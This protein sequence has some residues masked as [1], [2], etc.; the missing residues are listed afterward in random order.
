M[1]DEKP[2][3]EKRLDD[4]LE[5]GLKAL[6]N[7]QPAGEVNLPA[8]SAGLK[9]LVHLAAGIRD[10]P[11]PEPSV[12]SANALHARLAAEVRRPAPGKAGR[13]NVRWL[14]A[15]GLA[16]AGALFLC[17]FVLLAA[18]GLWWLGPLDART[19][20]LAD[21][22]GLVEAA[23]AGNDRWQA[24][25]NGD[26]LGAGQRIRTATDATAKLVFFDGTRTILGGGAEVMLTRLGGRWGD[27]L[28]AELTQPA[29]G[30]Q[31]EVVPFSSQNSQ[32]RVQTPAGLASVHGTVFQ[33]WVEAQG[34]AFFTVDR[35]AVVVENADQQ[36]NL[37]AGQATVS[38]TDAAPDAPSYRFSLSDR[39]AAVEGEVWTVGQVSFRVTAETVVAGDPQVGDLILAQGRMLTADDWVADHI[40][41]AEE[42]AAEFQFTGVVQAMDAEAWEINGVTVLVNEVT[43]VD[44][45]LALGDTALVIYT[46]LEGGRWLALNIEKLESAEE[47]EVPGT[48]S[49]DC[50]GSDPQPT[51]QKLAQQYGVT[52]EEI[53]GWF[54]Q[55]YGFGEIGLAYG[56]SQESGWAVADIFALRQQN[57]GWGEIKRRVRQTPTATLPVATL[58]VATLPVT[59]TLTAT[60]TPTRTPT[61]ALTATLPTATLPVT[62]TVTPSPTLSVT[63]TATPAITPTLSA[64]QTA[65]CTGADPQPKGQD[66]AAQY[67]VSYEEI[68]GWFCQGFGF[69]EIDLAYSLSVQSGKPVA[70]IFALKQGGMGWGEIKKLLQ[71]QAKP[72]DKDKKKDK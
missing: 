51:A 36:V 39:L 70:E 47:G 50:T 54:C 28:Q 60:V 58:P 40:A 53:M 59:V 55:G 42:T 9:P 44:G 64:T 26:H 1:T 23:P 6:E 10:L 20:T 5:T 33:V 29:G 15:A 4:Q 21:V 65:L 27:V 61:P 16:G 11:H 7:G 49:A 38:R 25:E 72:K 37:A 24:V 34:Q 18:G 69:G 32:F 8:E 46:V 17:A 3:D 19:V 14:W 63:L 62:L 56:L 13:L 71:D 52:Y 67:G 66:L 31:Y 41:L 57:L 43:E 35:G 12:E 2:L 68:M 48:P 30:V 22:S 45:D